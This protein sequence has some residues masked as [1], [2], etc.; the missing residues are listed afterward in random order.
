MV[1]R[2]P[3]RHPCIDCGDQTTKK[4]CKPCGYKNRVLIPWNKGTIGLCKPNKTSFSPGIVPWNKGI[5]LKQRVTY[6]ELH[7]WVRKHLGSPKQCSF[8]E[9]TT[10]IEWA[11]KSR[12][13]KRDLS[14]WVPLCVPCHR[15]YDS[16]EHRGKAIEIFGRKGVACL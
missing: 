13:Y 1:K 8:C 15:R 11:N 6:K 14:D 2:E 9:S 7:K 10:K 4:R 3:R 12:E 16:G 5:I